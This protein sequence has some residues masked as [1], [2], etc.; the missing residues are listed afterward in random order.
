MRERDNL[1]LQTGQRRAR[2]A[3][4]PRE[5][6]TWPRSSWQQ[7]RQCYGSSGHRWRMPWGA[8]KPGRSKSVRSDQQEALRR[9][10]PGATR[11]GRNVAPEG[12]DFMATTPVVSRPGVA[13]ADPCKKARGMGPHR[14][15]G[16][17]H[18]PLIRW[19]SGEGPPRRW[20]ARLALNHTRCHDA[21]H[22]LFTTAAPRGTSPLVLHR[23]R[24]RLRSHLLHLRSGQNRPVD[25]RR[26]HDPG[27]AIVDPTPTPPAGASP[28][29][30]AA[31]QIPIGGNRHTRP[32]T[33]ALSA[34]G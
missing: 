5:A 16:P 2:R 15:Q 30:A 27:T 19:F 17:T 33:P 32:P 12:R 21:H 31:R 10:Y 18:K 13:G 29:Q 26:D 28:T 23:C 9:D 24:P 20:G 11:G 4:R 6:R 8:P 25:R 22:R 14:R 7:P 34:R 1:A 3:G